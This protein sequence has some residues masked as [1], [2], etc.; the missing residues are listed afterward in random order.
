MQD[1]GCSD[2]DDTCEGSIKVRLD[3]LMLLCDEHYKNRIRAS[4][5]KKKREMD[6]MNRN[7]PWAAYPW[8]RCKAVKEPNSSGHWGRCD[9]KRHPDELDHALERGMDILRWSTNWTS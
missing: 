8:D 6:K 3:L 4:E 1:R 2:Y 7:L 5:R 9:L